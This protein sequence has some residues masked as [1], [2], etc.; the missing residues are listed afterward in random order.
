MELLE[1]KNVCSAAS[2]RGTYRQVVDIG[3]GTTRLVPF[4]IIPMSE[5]QYGIEVK[6]AVKDSWLQDGIMKMIWVVVRKP[7]C[8]L[9]ELF[10]DFSKTFKLNNDIVTPFKF[11]SFISHSLMS[12]YV[13]PLYGSKAIV[14]IFSRSHY[15]EDENNNLPLVSFFQSN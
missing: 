11:Y 2:K 1:E 10:S 8:G 9:F 3:P 15:L 6:A 4:I 7:H 13:S 12:M 14:L 5:G